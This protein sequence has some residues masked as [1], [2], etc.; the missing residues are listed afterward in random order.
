MVVALCTSIHI[1]SNVRT[2]FGNRKQGAVSIGKRLVSMYFSLSSGSSRLRKKVVQIL[3]G[4]G[5]SG[6]SVSNT[7]G[8]I[9]P[10]RKCI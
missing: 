6:K 7:A 3:T 4:G 8:R 2:K 10:G 1:R 5:V 9:G